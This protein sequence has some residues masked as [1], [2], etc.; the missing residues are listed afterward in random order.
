MTTTGS[1]PRLRD[2]LPTLD[3]GAESDE[4]SFGDL[5]N[6]LKSA[7]IHRLRD[8]QY[9]TPTELSENVKCSLGMAKRLISD[10]K[11]TLRGQ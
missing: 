2:W 9:W 8:F 5:L 6:A 1:G 4:E 7:G 3:E 10:A 11:H